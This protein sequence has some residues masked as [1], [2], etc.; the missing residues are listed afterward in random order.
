MFS[1]QFKCFMKDFTAAGGRTKT[2]LMRRK[3]DKGGRA[4]G[5]ERIEED[6]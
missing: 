2:G 5:E 1:L 4:G 3:G 6:E